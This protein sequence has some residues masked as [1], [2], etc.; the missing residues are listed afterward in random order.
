ME[1]KIVDE[2]CDEPHPRA[3]WTFCGKFPFKEVAEGRRACRATWRS[4]KHLGLGYT[5][6][7]LA[8][9]ITDEKSPSTN[10]RMLHVQWEYEDSFEGGENFCFLESLQAEDWYLEDLDSTA[11]K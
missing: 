1:Q 2:L 11:L 6:C 7:M 4:G 10:E 5:P 8:V 9:V 3:T